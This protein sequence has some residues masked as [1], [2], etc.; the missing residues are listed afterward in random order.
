MYLHDDKE[1]F[2]EII[3]QVA[4][5]TGR[6]EIIIEKDYYVT[7]LLKKLANKLS[8]VVFKGGT[9]LSKGYK[10]INRF[11]E[12]IDITFDEHLGE[13]RRKKLKNN[14]L[15]GIS[16]ELNMPIINW[17]EIQSDRDY[18]AT[19]EQMKKIAEKI[20]RFE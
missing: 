6:T 20:E 8:N 1:I 14:I 11:S 4:A 2:K 10:I 7:M 12:D 5:E 9:S 15:K 3:E 18:N 13:A 17:N 19:I 16:D